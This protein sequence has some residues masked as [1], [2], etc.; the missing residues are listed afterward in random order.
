MSCYRSVKARHT[1]IIV[2]ASDHLQADYA[3]AL[4]IYS[5]ARHSDL[6]QKSSAVL[7]RSEGR[8]NERAVDG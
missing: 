6:G 2:E 4:Q 7:Q 1:C 8:L 3:S 5:Y